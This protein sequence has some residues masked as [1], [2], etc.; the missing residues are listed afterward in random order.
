MSNYGENKIEPYITKYKTIQLLN[1]VKHLSKTEAEG[2]KHI[3]CVQ[4]NIEK[5]EDNFNI[6]EEGIKTYFSM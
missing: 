4:L 5:S 1:G 3:V 2:L 6:I